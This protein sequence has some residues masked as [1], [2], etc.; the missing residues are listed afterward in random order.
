[1]RAKTQMLFD[2]YWLEI[3]IKT[4]QFNSPHVSSTM[5]T[6]IFFD[7]DNGE[8]TIWQTNSPHMKP[9][10]DKYSAVKPHFIYSCVK[11]DAINW[12]IKPYRC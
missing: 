11:Y 5:L 7:N 3:E 2:Y 10:L 8:R 4:K 1:M 9:H 6:D 12:V